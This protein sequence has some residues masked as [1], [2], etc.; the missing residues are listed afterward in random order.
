[1]HYFG[2]C[3]AGSAFTSAIGTFRPCS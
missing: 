2:A 1:M 3:E